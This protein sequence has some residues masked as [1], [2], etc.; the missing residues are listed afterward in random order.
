MDRVIN[1]REKETSTCESN[2]HGEKKFIIR[3]VWEY[4]KVS[5]R[6]SLG[7]ERDH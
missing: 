2:R 5:C 1:V 7:D 4:L 6:D 3:E